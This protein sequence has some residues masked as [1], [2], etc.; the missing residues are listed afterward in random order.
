MQIQHDVENFVYFSVSVIS[1]E[2]MKLYLPM[3]LCNLWGNHGDYLRA[4]N[5]LL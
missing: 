1:F 5:F 4:I 2:F 3:L